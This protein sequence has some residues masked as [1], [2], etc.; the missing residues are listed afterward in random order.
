[1]IK[2]QKVFFKFQIEFQN[3]NARCLQVTEYVRIPYLNGAPE[4]SVRPAWVPSAE[5]PWFF[6]LGLRHAQC[7]LALKGP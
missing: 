6:A 2:T 1:M 5:C 7:E 3:S 4:R